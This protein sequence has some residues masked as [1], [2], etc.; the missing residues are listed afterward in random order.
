MKKNNKK[1]VKNAP[2]S[3]PVKPVY[4]AMPTYTVVE[5]AVASRPCPDCPFKLTSGYCANN[6]QPV[7]PK[8]YAP[9][10]NNTPLPVSAYSGPVKAVEPDRKYVAGKVVKVNK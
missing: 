4:T 3:T 7:Q 5:S 2:Q 9:V 1:N 6:V 8:T 10:Q